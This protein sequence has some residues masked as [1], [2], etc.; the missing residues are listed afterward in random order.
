[1]LSVLPIRDLSYNESDVSYNVSEVSNNVTDVSYNVTVM[2][3][4]S[5]AI[6]GSYYLP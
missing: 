1:M 6:V 2:T 3:C 4:I 5:Y